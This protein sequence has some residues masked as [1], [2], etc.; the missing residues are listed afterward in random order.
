MQG[1]ALTL[2]WN[3]GAQW[4]ISPNTTLG[5][6]YHYQDKF[7]LSGDCDLDTTGGGLPVT[8]PMAHYDIEFDFTWPQSLGVGITHGFKDDHRISADVKWIDWF[9]AFD[10]VWW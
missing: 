9:S 6:A 10:M 4:R 5:I 8:D 7:E 2:A 1:D 3:I